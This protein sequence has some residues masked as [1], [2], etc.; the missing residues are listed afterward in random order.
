MDYTRA[1]DTL[2]RVKT[3]ERAGS[4]HVLSVLWELKNMNQSETKRDGHFSDSLKV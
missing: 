3:E 4:P 1:R 2:K